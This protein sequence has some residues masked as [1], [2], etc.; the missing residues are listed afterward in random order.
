MSWADFEDKLNVLCSGKLEHYNLFP[1]SF[2]FT[3]RH[4]N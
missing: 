3:L 2:D 1:T 4:I